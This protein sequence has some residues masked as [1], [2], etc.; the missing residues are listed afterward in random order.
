MKKLVNKHILQ[1]TGGAACEKKLNIHFYPD[2]NSAN[3]SIFEYNYISDGECSEAQD[4][5]F[6]SELKSAIDKKIGISTSFV[7]TLKHKL[8][9][10]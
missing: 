2:P 8:G 6:L 5:V 7:A 4:E 9:V 1:V 3:R 10:D